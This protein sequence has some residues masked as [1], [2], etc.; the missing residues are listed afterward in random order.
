MHGKKILRRTFE[1]L[2]ERK[3]MITFEA[4]LSKQ[5][6][7][8]DPIGDLARDFISTKKMYGSK[9]CTHD[10][11]TKYGAIKEAHEA[12]DAALDEYHGC[13]VGD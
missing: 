1:N 5:K 4:W 10:Q 6:M 11:L 13:V 8:Q 3:E 2:W 7:R 12:L 9:K